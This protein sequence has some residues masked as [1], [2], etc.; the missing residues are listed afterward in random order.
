M[1]K[2]HEF[3]SSIKFDCRMVREDIQVSIAH[4]TMLGEC[5]II[6]KSDREE[7]ITGLEEIQKEIDNG[8]LAFDENAEDVHMFIEAE[9][10]RRIGEPGKRLHTARSR[11]DQVAT[12][13]R[14]VLRRETGEIQN[15]LIQLV[16]T[17]CELG[18]EHF[19]TVMPGYTHLQ[20]A[21]PVT[22]WAHLEAYVLMVSRDIAR[23]RDAK[24]LMNEGCPLGACALAGTTYPTDRKMT[25]E[26]LGF[27]DTAATNTLDDVSDRD[28]C[29]EITSAL[30]IIMMHLS[31]FSEEIILWCSRE[32][33]FIELGE[34]F[35]TGS[36]IM[37]QK[38]NPD[39]AELVR[40]KAARVFG[41]LQTLLVIMKGLPLAYNK[42]MQE[43][44][45]AVFDAVDTVK[46]CLGVF[47]PMIA[48]VKV[49]AANMRDAASKGF[50]NA[51]DCADYLVNKGIAFR[52]AYNITKEVVA[53]CMNSSED[54]DL[55]TLPITEYQKFCD[56]FDEDVYEAVK[57]ENCVANREEKR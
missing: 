15:L 47:T 37:P 20:R 42:D 21:Q 32:F 54:Y 16:Q 11:N 57:L 49:N 23:L 24:N 51:T 26:L 19:N 41:D 10:T 31:R 33:G 5:G 25:A 6:S 48:S 52:D 1:D 50:L 12:D 40:G 55:E 34:S 9:L 17:L 39:V 22:F 3:N 38:K 36:S 7:I 4:A 18:K 28:F 27:D 14:M 53:F 8:S 13:L 29:I 30:S 56:V 46:M 43:T 45:E 2:V 35:T 44:Q